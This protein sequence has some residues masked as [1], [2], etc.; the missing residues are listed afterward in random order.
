MDI[1]AWRELLLEWMSKTSLLLVRM[2]VI[3]RLNN[4]LVLLGSEKKPRSM[5][6]SD[7]WIDCGGA[8]SW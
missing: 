4:W 7:T 8:H 5:R 2:D 3:E 6:L 1:P